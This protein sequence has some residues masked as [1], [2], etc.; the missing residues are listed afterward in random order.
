GTATCTTS[1]A[2]HL[3]VGTDVVTATYLGDSNHSGSAGSENQVVQGGIA[4]TIDVTNVSPASEDFGADAPAMITAVLSWTGNGVAPTGSNVTISGNGNGTYSATSCAAR[5]HKTIT[6]TATYTPNNSDVAGSY[7]ETASFSGDTNYSPSSSPET[8]NFTIGAATSTT[9]VAG[10]PNPSVYATSVTFTATITGENGLV[11]GN[12]SKKPLAVSGTVAWSANTGCSPSTVSGGYPGVATCTTSSATHLPVGANTV[13]ATY[14]GD[15]NHSGSTGTMTQNVTGGIA[16]TINVTSVSPAAE[17]YAAD[18]PATITA[19]LTWTGNGVAPTASDV[20]ISGNG[21]GTYGAT[22]CGARVGKTITCTA[23]Y[24]PSNA[25]VAGSY[26][27][28]ATFSGDTNYS[29]STSSQT[30]NFTITSATSTTA[31]TSA[32]NPST[33]GGAVTFTA[34]VDGENGATRRNAKRKPLNVTGSVT[35]SAN[36]G[37]SA[38]TVSGYPGVATCTTSSLLGGTDSVTAT[39]GG[40]SNHSGSSGSVSQVVNPASQTITC[41]SLPASE[42]YNTSF[43]ASCSA[44]SSLPVSYTSAGGCTNSGA[45]YTMTSGTTACLVT[46]SQGGNGNYSAATPVNKSVAA[47]LAPQSITVTTAAPP[48]AIDGSVFT[49]VASAS[50]GLPITYTS[51]GACTNSGATYTINATKG[52]CTVRMT[53]GGNT[54]YSAATPVV[55]T[56]TVKAAKKP[57]VSFTG[58]PT[59]AAYG[60]TFTVT[61]SSN[62]AGSYVSIPTLTT[63]TPSVCSVSG[64]TTSGSS[65]SATVTMLTGT[66]ECDV[67]AQWTANYVYA[68]AH[69]TKHTLAERATP[70]VHFTGAPATITHGNTFTVDATSNESGSLVSVPTIT[71][72]T[73][74]VCTVG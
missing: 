61:A 20:T 62:E 31:V 56:T 52:T 23:T 63:S 17:D 30:N 45:T 12:K 40:D 25:D 41:G 29:G 28:T 54:N 11:K 27:E 6:C 60:A 14:S 42:P 53:Q 22:S 3:P 70:A 50:S 67:T 59:K 68:A 58:M 19:V 21:N 33:Y 13:T 64:I 71:T 32:L 1:A 37:C 49:I 16:T 7:T 66:L 73:A 34:T 9:S 26:T 55:E 65:V 5:V 8:N 15:S 2:T 57:V 47:T 4:T 10:S 46:A 51:A 24:T 72:T 48:N 36:T 43:T 44:S 74:T 38:S 69:V 35:W 18:A 39:Y